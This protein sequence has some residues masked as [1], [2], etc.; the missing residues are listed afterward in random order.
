MQ[1]LRQSPMIGNLAMLVV[2]YGVSHRLFDFAW[3]G[4]LRSVFPTAS[5]YQVC[6]LLG[7]SCCSSMALAE[8]LLLH[9]IKA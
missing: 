5:D 6:I 9:I 1:V 8:R 7:V 3:K 4:Q 2:S